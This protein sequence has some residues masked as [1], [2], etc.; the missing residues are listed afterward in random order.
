[1]WRPSSAL[2]V[3]GLL[4]SL[5]ACASVPK[6][7]YGVR[8]IK[9]EGMRELDP[10][11]LKACLATTERNYVGLTLGRSADPSCGR[12]PFAGKRLELRMGRWPWS[13][14][15]VFDEAVFQR[16]IERVRRWFR[17]RGYYDAEVEELGFVPEAMKQSDRFDDEAAPCDH[18]AGEGCEAELVLKVR[19][20]SPVQIRA[21]TLSGVSELPEGLRSKLAG[22]LRFSRGEPFDEAVYDMVKR[23]FR[24]L[25]AEAAFA[26]AEVA[27]RVEVD[28]TARTADVY[29]YVRAG[30]RYRFGRVYVTGKRA[31]SQRPILASAS[32]E[33][34]DAYSESALE[35]AEREVYALGAFSSVEIQPHFNPS[36]DVHVVDVEIRVVPGRLTRFGLGVGLMSGSISTISN[37]QET[38]IPQWDVHLLAIAE[39]RNFLGGLRRVRLEERPRLIF[40]QVFPQTEQGFP[41]PGNLAMLEF[42]QPS[43]IEDRTTLV[44]NL[45]WDLGPDPFQARF[46]RHDL[47]ARLGPQRAFLKGRLNVSAAVH[48]NWLFVTQIRDRAPSDY[49][50]AFWEQSIRYDLR[51]NPV[52][53]HRGIFL[54]LG[55]QQAGYGLPASWRYFR[56]TPDARFYIPLPYEVVL[57]G[58]FALGMLFIQQSDQA[59]DAISA[60]LGPERYRLRGGG[61]TSNRGFVPGDLGD[62]IEGGL[63]RWE[64]SLELR[65]MLTENFG[66]VLFTD[67]GDVHESASFRFSHL[68]TS[69]GFGLRYRTPVG[70]L[71]FDMGFVVDEARVIGDDAPQSNFLVDLGFTQFPGA[72]HLTI[73]E[74]F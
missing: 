47:D 26:R 68:N 41:S 60:R 52:F 28:P 53:P 4:G 24:R 74:S 43:F 45:R 27:G 34:G 58:R 15:P 63:R 7:R 30:P 37:L 69:V 20:G 44:A 35:D 8:R 71:R 13:K 17:A 12:P 70:P 21:I 6:G 66:T 22:A 23:D 54:A 9:V 11:S 10:E 3:L 48:A 29:L 64:S 25:L 40:E 57:A 56:T 2:C 38:T 72:F 49:F 1:M 33:D 46:S 61:A 42:R 14:W 55:L 16:D 50:L 65:A 51:D 32:I 62:G 59:L 36:P 18:D 5:A 31:L 67:F 73:G 19:E 39:H